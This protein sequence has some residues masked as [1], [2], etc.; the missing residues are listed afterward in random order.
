MTIAERVQDSAVASLIQSPPAQLGAMGVTVVATAMLLLLNV[1]PVRAASDLGYARFCQAEPGCDHSVRNALP[2]EPANLH[3]VRFGDLRVGMQGPAVRSGLLLPGGPAAVLGTVRTVVVGP[4]ELVLRAR[5]RAHIGEKGF[6]A[7][8]PA[9]A[10]RDPSSAVAGPRSGVGIGAP[11]LH[12]LPHG[13]FRC[14]ASA[15]DGVPVGRHASAKGIP[16]AA[17]TGA[18]LAPPKGL[19][20][21]DALEPACASAEPKCVAARR[22]PG[23]A[24]YGQAPKRLT[25]DIDRARLPISH[26]SIVATACRDLEA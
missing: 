3:D 6:V 20:V 26:A 1:L 23:T 15:V 24:K 18:G 5:A 8:Q 21:D 16:V 7:L 12:G 14:S 4:I 17:S 11:L 19:G 10:D 25:R 13:V 22:A 2:P 9:P